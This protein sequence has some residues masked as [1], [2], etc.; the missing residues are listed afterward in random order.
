MMMNVYRGPTAEVPVF[1][2]SE[3]TASVETRR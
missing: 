2:D 3:F 1:A